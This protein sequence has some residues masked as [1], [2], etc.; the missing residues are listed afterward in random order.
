MTLQG[1]NFPKQ[2]EK[3]S[4]I[5]AKFAVI[6]GEEE[7]SSGIYTCKNLS[8]GIQEKISSFEKLVEKLSLY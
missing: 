5:G 2:M 6:W 4:K 3:A 8:T 1:E 7:I